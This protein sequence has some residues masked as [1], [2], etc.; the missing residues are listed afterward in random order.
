[1]SSRIPTKITTY[2]P[3]FTRSNPSG[4]SVCPGVAPF[5]ASLLVRLGCIKVLNTTEGSSVYPGSIP[6]CHGSSRFTLV[7]QTGVN[8]AAKQDNENIAFILNIQQNMKQ[9]DK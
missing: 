9:W 8:R 4:I 6:V 1:M 7:Y 2:H 5:L 3:G